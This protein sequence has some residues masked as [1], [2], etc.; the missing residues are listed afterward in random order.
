[1]TRFAIV[2]VALLVLVLS[3]GFSST[4]LRVASTQGQL[5]Q[6]SIAKQLGPADAAIS[7]AVRPAPP[8]ARILSGPPAA[9][10]PAPALLIYLALVLV[11]SAVSIAIIRRNQV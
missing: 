10:G 3:S 7:L 6:P 1:M 8:G 4:Q 5:A 11:G 2:L 9:D